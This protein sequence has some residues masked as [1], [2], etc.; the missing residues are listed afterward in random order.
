MAKNNRFITT[1]A[2]V[3]LAL[4]FFVLSFASSY[5]LLDAAINQDV[6]LSNNV[7]ITAVAPPGTLS[8]KV[9][10]DTFTVPTVGNVNSSAIGARAYD[11]SISVDGGIT[12]TRYQGTGS[13]AGIPLENI[14]G[15][16]WIK[17]YDGEH[18]NGWLSAFGFNRPEDNA[19]A[20][21][22]QANR[23]KLTVV[24][25]RD[26]EGN[27]SFIPNGTTNAQ[28]YLYNTFYSCTN[29]TDI[30]HFEIPALPSTVTNASNYLSNI[31]NK[32]GLTSL[33]G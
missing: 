11:W 27:N 14:T 2:F 15:D 1:F 29:L 9:N 25:F 21:G 4:V 30:S 23:N 5:N 12:W 16:I 8:L 33:E 31:F 18:T 32:S 10:S 19:G 22:V 6:N 24:E 26:E 17:E 3:A 13:I 20:S 28:Y 7:K